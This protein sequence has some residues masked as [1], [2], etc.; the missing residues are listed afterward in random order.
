MLAVSSLATGAVTTRRSRCRSPWA[1]TS[2]S[3]HQASSGRS[4]VVTAGASNNRKAA[5]LATV[6]SRL[7]SSTD[8]GDPRC[9]Q[10]EQPEHA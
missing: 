8:M 2:S 10:V 3:A 4:L 9:L 1:L 5:S 6:R 7:E